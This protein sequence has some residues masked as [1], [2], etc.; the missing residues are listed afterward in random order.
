[1]VEKINLASDYTLRQPCGTQTP[2][3]PLTIFPHPY[4]ITQVALVSVIASFIPRILSFAQVKRLQMPTREAPHKSCGLPENP[5]V[6][7]ISP[8]CPDGIIL[9]AVSRFVAFH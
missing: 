9:C 2:P 4:V 6:W 7:T 8:R 3:T 5:L 1:M